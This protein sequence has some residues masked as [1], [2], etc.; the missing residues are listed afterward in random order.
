MKN[1]PFDLKVNLYIIRPN[2]YKDDPYFSLL[3]LD[4]SL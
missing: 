3:M 4:F 2:L 1:T